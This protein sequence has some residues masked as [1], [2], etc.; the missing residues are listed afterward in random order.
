[1]IKKSKMK[2]KPTSLPRLLRTHAAIF[3]PLP[4]IP[5][6]NPAFTYEIVK[7]IK[8]GNLSMALP[9]ILVLLLLL[10]LTSCVV[11]LYL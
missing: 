1:M 9:I 3:S 4:S 6:F 11:A 2:D 7:L 5:P 10:V 8:D